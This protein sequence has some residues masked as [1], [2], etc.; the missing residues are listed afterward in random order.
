MS[1]PS[2]Q[3][4]LNQLKTAMYNIAVKGLA[5]YTTALGQTYT[6]LNM[7]ELQEAIEIYET[8]VNRASGTRRVFAGM[9]FGRMR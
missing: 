1:V 4:I 3:E 8:R 5:S 2:D 9:T 7:K 6:S